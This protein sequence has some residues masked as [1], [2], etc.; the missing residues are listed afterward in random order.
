MRHSSTAISKA[1]H[2]YWYQA[3]SHGKAACSRSGSY[4]FTL[5]LSLQSCSDYNPVE[6]PSWLQQDSI[7]TSTF[8]WDVENSPDNVPL[9]TGHK[10]GAQ[11]G[12]DDKWKA[13]KRKSPGE[14]SL[15]DIMTFVKEKVSSLKMN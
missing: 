1:K 7:R 4:K 8:H 14:G 13:K 15:E 6:E 2:H 10:I 11:L 5:A 12:A 3:F 9:R